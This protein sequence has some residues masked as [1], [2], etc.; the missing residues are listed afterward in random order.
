MRGLLLPHK[1]PFVGRPPLAALLDQRL[2]SHQRRRVNVIMLSR[3]AT[4]DGQ[5]CLGL[6]TAE[7]SGA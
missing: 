5:A 7:A 1:G 3:P 4:T 6:L 2:E